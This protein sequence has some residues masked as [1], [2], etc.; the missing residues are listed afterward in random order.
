MFWLATN[1][2]ETVSLTLSYAAGLSMIVLPCTLPL[3]FVIVPLSMGKGYKKGFL[4]AILFS[5]GLII[6]LSLYGVVVALAGRAFSLQRVT[7]TMYILAGILAFVFGLSELKLIHFELPSYAGMPGFIQRQPEYFKAFLLGLFLGNAGIGCPNPATYVILTYIASAGSVIQGLLLQAV[8]GIGRA[9]PLIFLSILGVLGVNATQAI[10]KRKEFINK[11]TGWGLVF[12]GALIIVWGLY[13]HYWFLN[14]PIH[15]GWTRAFGTISG[16]VAEYEC[17]IE[18]PCQMCARG[19][20]IFDEKTCLCRIHLEQGHMDKVCPECKSGLA[21]GK[22]IYD[23]AE[24]TQY[25]AFGILTVLSIIPII[26]Y[27]WKKPF[28]KEVRKITKKTELKKQNLVFGMVFVLVAGLLI[29]FFINSLRTT[30]ENFRSMTIDEQREEWMEE[31]NIIRAST[32][33]RCCLEKPCWYCIQKTPGHGE[34]AKCTCLDDVMAGEHPCGECIGEILEGHG[35]KSLAP[36]YA[37]AIA[38]K[39]G[40]QHVDHLKSIIADMYDITVEEQMN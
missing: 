12:F 10:I 29:G 3:V 13:G 26:W 38:H 11:A 37:K 33:Y 28:K 19:E 16:G 1:P 27:L 18:P 31:A 24:S 8:N 39:V 35:I 21:T 20:W 4:M 30:A 17:C 40:E 5:I 34:G 6:T 23:I 9:V 2:G 25:P 7:Q 32:D 14:T 36:Y 22:G 15:K